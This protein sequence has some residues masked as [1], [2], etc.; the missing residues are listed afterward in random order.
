ML[1]LLYTLSDVDECALGLDNCSQH[2]AC[3]DTS[4]SYS[5][6]CLSGYSGNGYICE[7]ENL[8]DLHVY[9]YADATV[10]NNY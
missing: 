4:S 2:A 6:T 9:N 1:S 10:C 5:C 8:L 3:I 7:G